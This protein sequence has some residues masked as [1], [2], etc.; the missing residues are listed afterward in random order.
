MATG[1]LTI[2]GTAI[3]TVSS[4][5]AWFVLGY[6]FFA[7]LYAAAGSLVSRQEDVDVT[8]PP[9]ALVLMGM[10][11]EA[12]FVARNP[13]RCDAMTQALGDQHRGEGV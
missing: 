2:T 9:L 11:M 12:F 1:S 10:V 3:I 13:E 4:A 8:T 5:L 7:V 6:A